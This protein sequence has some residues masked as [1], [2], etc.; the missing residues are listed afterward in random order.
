M[1]SCSSVNLQA[2]ILELDIAKIYASKEVK[3]KSLLV[4]KKSYSYSF[5]NV[6]NT[7]WHSFIKIQ[8]KIDLLMQP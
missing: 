8:H 5:S 2:L 1:L 7:M 3:T 4:Q 6:S